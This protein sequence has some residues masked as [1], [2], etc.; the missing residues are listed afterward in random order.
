M[1]RR[2]AL[3]SKRSGFTIVELL[4]VVIVISILATV[5][6]V[7]IR[8][9]QNRANDTAVQSDINNLVRT[10]KVYE[11]E[12]LALPAAGSRT[13]DSTLFP[14]ITARVT[15]ASYANNLDN[16]FY[17]EGTISTVA[18]FT[19]AAKSKSGNIFTYRPSEGIK[20]STATPDPYNQCQS[21]WDVGSS[22]YSYGFYNTTKTWYTWANQ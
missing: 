1:T 6:L 14:G 18:S 3:Q 4:I 12:N 10:V 2:I 13:G 11:G 17:C 15:K 5:T 16:F 9:V 19:I 21:G 7:S 8:G 22:Y 20:Q